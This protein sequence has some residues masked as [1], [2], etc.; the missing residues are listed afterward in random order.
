MQMQKIQKKMK[1]YKLFLIFAMFLIILYPTFGDITNDIAGNST[2]IYFPQNLSLSNTSRTLLGTD[3]YGVVNGNP[4]FNTSVFQTNGNSVSFDGTGDF[5][6]FN[7]PDAVRY[8]NV[9]TANWT[10]SLWFNTTGND[11]T[12]LVMAA[13]SDEWAGSGVGTEFYSWAVGIDDRAGSKRFGCNLGSDGSVTS[14]VTAPN[15]WDDG[16]WHHVVCVFNETAITTW[17]ITLYID[18]NKTATGTLVQGI[19]KPFF[20]LTIGATSGTGGTERFYKGFIDEVTLINRSLT[21]EEIKHLYNLTSNGT[22]VY[23]ND[24]IVEADTT[25]PIVNATF[26]NTSPKIND[27]INISANITDETGLSTANITINFTTGTV[28]MN[29]SISGTSA[30]IYNVTQITDGRG[31]VL[32]ITVYATDTSNN[33]KQNSTLITIADTLGSIAIGKNGTSF[34]INGVINIS[35]NITEPDGDIDY[36]KVVNNQTGANVEYAFAGSGSRFNF[37]QNMT[38]GVGRGNVINFTASYNDTAGSQIS[39]SLLFTIT[40]AKPNASRITN[41]TG[42]HYTKNI[43]FNWTAG[44]DPDLDAVYHLVYWSGDGISFNL[45]S[46]TTQT[47]S[48]S[49]ATAD[50]T[51]IFIVNTTDYFGEIIGGA[52]WNFTL[53]TGLPTLTANCTNSTFTRVNLTCL[54]SIEDPF[55]YNLSVLVNRNGNDYHIKTNSTALGGFINITFLPNLTEDGNYTIYVNASDSDKTSPKIDDNYN[56]GKKGESELVFNN[57][58]VGNSVSMKIYFVEKL[59]KLTDTPSTLKSF[60]EFNAKGT[61]IDFGV[62]FTVAKPETKIVFNLSINKGNFDVVKNSQ[63]KGH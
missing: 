8:H 4:A 14:V 24:V 48:S 10:V 21:G 40:N 52:V 13:Q 32:N 46:N 45:Y 17:T 20:P 3:L 6:A 34:E 55:P 49:N 56:K 11:E 39:S 5:I 63:T 16:K 29:Y 28:K 25:K 9:T 53:D 59:D 26:N 2:L 61:H 41:V 22:K 44:I 19:G 1:P 54:Y 23:F 62:N 18:G 33:V 15:T 51:Y 30:S 36:G 7:S 35:G 50:G 42:R 47:N 58:D 31:N 43:T 27:Y 38:I 12:L 37:S 60:S 57:T